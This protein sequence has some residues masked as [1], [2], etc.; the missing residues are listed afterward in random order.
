MAFSVTRPLLV[1]RFS[2]VVAAVLF[3]D[4]EEAVVAFTFCGEVEFEEP[5]ESKEELASD[6]CRLRRLTY[7]LKLDSFE[8]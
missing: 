1:T 7:Q 4:G 3:F 5:A 8:M 6:T 2:G